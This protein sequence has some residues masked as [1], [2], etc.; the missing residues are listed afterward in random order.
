MSKDS[1]GD[2]QR[3][4]ELW[5]RNAMTNPTVAFRDFAT[6]YDA[7]PVPVQNGHLQLTAEPSASDVTPWEAVLYA[8]LGAMP[9]VRPIFFDS[10]QVILDQ[11]LAACPDPE[12]VFA[13]IDNRIIAERTL[14]ER[15]SHQI[16]AFLRYGVTLSISSLDLAVKCGLNAAQ[17]STAE[18]LFPMWLNVYGSPDGNVILAFTKWLQHLPPPA[19]ELVTDE[20]REQRRRDFRYHVDNILSSMP[21]DYKNLF[22]EVGTG[23][24]DAPTETDGEIFAAWVKGIESGE[25]EP[26]PTYDERRERAIRLQRLHVPDDYQDKIPPPSAR[27]IIQRLCS[28]YAMHLTWLLA[29]IRQRIIGKKV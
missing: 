14:G 12:R 28:E 29:R 15:T 25:I 16:N 10:A 1:D 13:L 2:T 3:L 11:L 5:Y 21:V 26:P 20:L 19:I 7:N 24:Y 17:V 22:I 27:Q 6:R 23:G 4:A 18:M 9:A 8:P